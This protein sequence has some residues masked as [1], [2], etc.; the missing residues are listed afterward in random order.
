M[1][2]NLLI[3]LVEKWLYIGQLIRLSHKNVKLDSV[4]RASVDC[5]SV[6]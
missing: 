4:R 3:F 2:I 1:F 6:D 5:D